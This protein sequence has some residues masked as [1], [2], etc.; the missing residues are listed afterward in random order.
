[1][2]TERKFEVLLF[3]LGGVL[4]HFTGFEELG[5]LL[6]DAPD[7]A[8]VRHRWICSKAVHLFESGAISPPEFGLR[9]VEEWNLRLSPEG[10]LREFER[11]PRGLYPGA[12]PLLQHLRKTYR[13][14]CLSNSNEL[15]THLHRQ[16]LEGHLEQFFFSHEL[17]LAKPQ[18]EIFDFV[19][20]ELGCPPGRIAFFDDTA[21]NVRAGSS[22]GM[23]AYLA[24]GLGNLKRQLV[25]LGVLEVETG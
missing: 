25:D 10:F 18:P 20:D 13:L 2:L 7:S 11:W 12:G 19:V 8:T 23:K 21:V 9:L 4:V 14:A 6:P 16:Y 3:D 17:G 22:A 24:D 1:M 15:H 5:Y